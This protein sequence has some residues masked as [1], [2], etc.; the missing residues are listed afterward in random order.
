MH[1]PETE[2]AR[3]LR[4]NMTNVER[5]VWS[6]L[7]RRQLAGFKFRRQVPLG[8]YFANFYCTSARIVV[9]VDGEGHEE[10]SDER[11]NTWLRARGYQVFRISASDV[12]ESIEDAVGAI[13]QQLIS[14]VPPVLP[15][16][17]TPP[18]LSGKGLDLCA[19]PRA[20]GR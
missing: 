4:N 9:E 15:A 16:C 17:Q 6:R 7:C 14:G 12:Y 10:E 19:P 11:K 18:A 20:A 2:R 1:S 8:P 3:D 13:Y 5:F